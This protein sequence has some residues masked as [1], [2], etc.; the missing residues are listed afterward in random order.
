MRVTPRDDLWRSFYSEPN[1]TVGKI[2]DVEIIDGEEVV[3]SNNG[4]ITVRM[5]GN[6]IKYNRRIYLGGE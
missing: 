5:E 6:F 1:Y 2:Y 3:R 4:R